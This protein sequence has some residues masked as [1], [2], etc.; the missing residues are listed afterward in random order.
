MGPNR[1]L[2]INIGY[3]TLSIIKYLEP[4]TRNLH[5]ARYAD[6]VFDEDHFPALGGDRHLEEYREIEWNASRKQSLDPCTSE[7]ELKVQRIIHL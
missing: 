3:V 2:G 6:C 4:M 5:T 1:K 7:S